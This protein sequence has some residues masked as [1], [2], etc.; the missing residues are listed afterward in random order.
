M[1]W[2]NENME[3]A[4]FD[5]CCFCIMTYTSRQVFSISFFFSESH[6]SGDRLYMCTT[7]SSYSLFLYLITNVLSL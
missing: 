5:Q 6:V 2:K 4:D 3:I 7:F 1:P